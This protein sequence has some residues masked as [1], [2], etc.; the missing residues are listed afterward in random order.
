MLSLTILQPTSFKFVEMITKNTC[1]AA[2]FSTVSLLACNPSESTQ[3]TSTSTPADTIET[4][5]E[6]T[7][8]TAQEDPELLVFEG[9]ITTDR[10]KESISKIDIHLQGKTGIFQTLDD[11][12][13]P[14]EEDGPSMPTFEDLNF[15]G[16]PDVRIPKAIGNANIYYAYWI[17]NPTTQQFEENTDMDLSLPSIDTHKK[18]ILSFERNSAASYVETIY[19]YQEGKFVATRIENKDYIDEKRYQSVIQERQTDGTMKEIQNKLV[20]DIEG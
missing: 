20:E 18:Q 11:L 17:Y 19:E 5:V 12:E 6:I 15:D 7:K 8:N 4:E 2:I 16:F 9:K 1:Y 3:E 14:Y 10:A 13:L